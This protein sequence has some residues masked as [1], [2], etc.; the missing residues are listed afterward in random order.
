MGAQNR[1]EIDAR[2]YKAGN[3]PL[4]AGLGLTMT[5]AERKAYEEKQKQA[6]RQTDTGNRLTSMQKQL[7]ELSAFQKQRQEFMPSMPRRVGAATVGQQ[8]GSTGGT[9]LRISQTGGMSPSARR[10]MHRAG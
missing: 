3:N 5:P 1:A 7:D 4:L 8:M 6:Q 2:R 10:R 9:G